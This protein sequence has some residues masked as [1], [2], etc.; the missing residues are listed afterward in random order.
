MT[1]TT[2]RF[3]TC[4]ALLGCLALPVPAAA[5]PAPPGP[6]PPP[7]VVVRGSGEIHAVPDMATIALGAEQLAKTPKE[8]QAGVATA[9]TAVQQRLA[10]AGV[11]KDA[12]R[13]TTYDVQA[14]F[15][16]ASGRQILR[17]YVARHTIEV[18]VDDIAKV[19]ELLDVAIAAGG[20]SVQGVRFDLKQRAALE[21]DAL[22]R[23]VADAR[24]RADALAAGAGTA[25]AAIVRI[26]EAGLG[27][28]PE[29]P[30]MRMAAQPMAADMAPPVAPGETVIRA[31]VT[32][33]ARLK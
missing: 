23:A 24:A 5:Q 3:A 16:Y 9:M 13:T 25:V 27:G 31:S 10:A 7:T 30:M 20:T 33:T 12:I 22:T 14:Q 8:A 18:R 6:P 15:D 19:G 1:P 4:L 2:S 26:E 29:P 21:R 11:P 28:G 17:G 32:L